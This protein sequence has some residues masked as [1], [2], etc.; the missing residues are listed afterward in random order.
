MKISFGVD[1]QPRV[2]RFKFEFSH[3]ELKVG[4]RILGQ[5]NLK[6]SVKAIPINY[7]GAHSTTDAIA[8]F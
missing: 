2:K 6:T 8:G 3:V 1:E 5:K 4:L 7:V